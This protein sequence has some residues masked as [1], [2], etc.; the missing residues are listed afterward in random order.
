[1]E[2]TAKKI[3]EE[4]DEIRSIISSNS[5]NNKLSLIERDIVMSK[6]QA[7]YMII[8]KIGQEMPVTETTS[9]V[10]QNITSSPKKVK[11]LKNQK[12]VLEIPNKSKEQIV[13]TE[14]IVN[15]A[16]DFL[17]IESASPVDERSEKTQNDELSVKPKQD[18]KIVAEKFQKAE[19]LINELM[20]K[21]VMRKDISSVMQTKPL[22]DI[23]V[24]IG[25]NE[26]FIFINE[27][28]NGD[29]ETYDKTIKI[30]NNVHNFNEA[31]NYLSQTFS[32]DF[33]SDTAHKLLELVRRRH[34]VDNE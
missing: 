24:A 22:K 12:P 34:I 25:V 5:I 16:E 1:M 11:V 29:A 20:A 23:V 10:E 4:L 14:E 15:K 3:I 21:Q 19:P 18:K 7:V 13:I 33:E 32:W 31:F 9:Q 2:P 17:E 8:S 30:L 26:R 27:L 28:F 6:L